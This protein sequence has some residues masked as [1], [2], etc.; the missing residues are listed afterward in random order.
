MCLFPDYG[1][2]P[3]TFRSS[4]ER[5]LSFA[6][7]QGPSRIPIFEKEAELL[8][9][10]L[11]LREILVA[12]RVKSPLPTGLKTQARYVNPTYS[13]SGEPTLNPPDLS[14]IIFPIDDV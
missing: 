5:Q 9:G 12:R 13:W 8:A 3:T 10:L 1:R 6:I 11:G 2:Q 14:P 7:F 4:T